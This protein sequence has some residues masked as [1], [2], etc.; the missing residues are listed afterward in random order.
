VLRAFEEMIVKMMVVGPLMRGLS[1]LFGFAGGGLV[2]A[3]SSSNPLP[4]LDA[5][6]YGPGYAGGGMI[7]GPGTG[8]SD[9]IVARVSHGEFITNAASTAKY[10]PLLEAINADRIPRFADGGIVGSAMNDNRFAA[11]DNRM[12]IAP[13]INIKVEGGSRGPEADA[14]LAGQI[15]K[16]VADSVRKVATEEIR[17]Q[18]RPGGILS[19]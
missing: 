11:N 18:M 17:R 10:R 15:G 4:G 13:N 8:T 19:R 3:G 1:G 9:S 7:Q 16:S 5:S 2:D 14:A 12:T 6:D